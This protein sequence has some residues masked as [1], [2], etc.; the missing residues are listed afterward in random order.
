MTVQEKVNRIII[1][2]RRFNSFV[3]D[4]KSGGAAC[5][6]VC[7]FGRIPKNRGRKLA[8]SPK[9]QRG[10]EHV[11]KYKYNE[12]II[13]ISAYVFFYKEQ[14]SSYTCPHTL[15]RIEYVLGLRIALCDLTLFPNNSKFS[16]PTARQRGQDVYFKIPSSSG[17]KPPNICVSSSSLSSPFFFLLFVT[18]PFIMRIKLHKTI[19]K[20]QT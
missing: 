19:V 5:A 8:I 18:F 10:E 9:L 2:F 11:C 3:T 15:Q 16:G 7:A 14:H 4:K 20:Q 17:V 6:K 12:S 1:L 13:N